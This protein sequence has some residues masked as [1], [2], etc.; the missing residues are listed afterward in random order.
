MGCRHR[1]W[2]SSLL[3]GQVLQE[4]DSNRHMKQP[5]G[6]EQ[7]GP[8]LVC[9]LNKAIYGLKQASRAWF[10]TVHSVLISLGFSQ[11]KADAS[12]FFRQRE[13]DVIYLLIYVDDMLI[14]E[15][16]LGLRGRVENHSEVK[17]DVS[18]KLA[19]NVMLHE[20]V[21]VN[22]HVKERGARDNVGVIDESPAVHLDPQK[23]LERCGRYL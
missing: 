19:C 4:C 17:A 5:I 7:G 11:S 18:S 14:I 12:M 23:D 22:D 9:K 8:H 16:S 10:L 3:I 6:F 13:C 2:P 1:H 15:T 21:K 20:D